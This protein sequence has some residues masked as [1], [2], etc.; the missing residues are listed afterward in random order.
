MNTKVLRV[1]RED[2]C[3]DAVWFYKISMAKK[4][5]LLQKLFAEFEGEEDIDAGCLTKEYFTKF[6]EIVRRDLFETMKS[7]VWW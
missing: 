3:R 5:N 1:K 4:T 2:I 7:E 6:F